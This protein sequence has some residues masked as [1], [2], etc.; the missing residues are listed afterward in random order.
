MRDYEIVLSV[1]ILEEYKAVAGR[2]AR[3]LYREGLLVIIGELERVAT[4]VEPS[5]VAFR[6]AAP[7][8]EVCLATV[9]AGGAVLITGNSRHF[10]QAR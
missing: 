5:D 8:D 3:A 1:P 10:T 2:F 6:L 4:L 9:T 7:D